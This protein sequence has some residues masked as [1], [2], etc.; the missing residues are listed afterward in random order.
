MQPQ[1]I[2]SVAGQFGFV[3]YGPNRHLPEGSYRL[4]VSWDVITSDR[5]WFENELCIT[6]IV[7][8][9]RNLAFH[10]VFYKDLDKRQYECKFYVSSDIA[11]SIAGIETRIRI[12]TP[13]RIMIRALDVEKLPDSE[14]IIKAPS[15]L[16]VSNWL[17][18][19]LRVSTVREDEAGV[20]VTQGAIGHVLWGPY[21]PLQAGFYQMLIELERRDD[22]VCHSYLG[23][24]E[25]V[26]GDSYLASVDVHLNALPLSPS[27][28]Y[29]D[30]ISILFEVPEDVADRANR[31]ALLELR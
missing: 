18:F 16:A 29:S 19:L 4:V 13:M 10:P 11:D 20:I 26:A 12:I 5:K 30:P 1:V 31:D 27:H 6:I 3:A 24:A 15:F 14:P 21:W 25:V 9:E 8:G 17:P 2:E 7:S 28:E 22:D 23:K